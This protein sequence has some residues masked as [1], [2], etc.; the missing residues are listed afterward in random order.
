MEA[1]KQKKIAFLVGTGGV[2]FVVGI[3]FWFL[4][5]GGGSA[6]AAKQGDVSMLLLAGLPLGISILGLFVAFAGLMVG[7]KAAF[8]DDSG[9]EPRD[10]EGAYIIAAFILDRKGDKVFDVDMHDP[11]DVR[12]YLQIRLTDGSAREVETAP[13]LFASIGE[14]MTG[15]A[16]VQ[17]RW[18]SGFVPNRPQG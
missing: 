2:M 14:G 18:L 7:W 12:Y 10:L 6:A 13:G 3:F 16:T 5:V 9:K 4:M 1:D 15:T 17:G 8:A 11:D